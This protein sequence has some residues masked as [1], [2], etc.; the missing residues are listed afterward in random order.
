M[1]LARMT[2]ADRVAIKTFARPLGHGMLNVGG[3]S[4]NG[5]LYSPVDSSGALTD[6]TVVDLRAETRGVMV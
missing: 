4:M 6:T 2:G 1:L 3:A 5:M